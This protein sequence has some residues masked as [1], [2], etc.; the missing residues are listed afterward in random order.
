MAKQQLDINVGV[1]GAPQVNADLD[2]IGNRVQRVNELADIG[3]SR[4]AGRATKEIREVGTIGATL[5]G[6]QGSNKLTNQ[7]AAVGAGMYAFNV[8][9]TAALNVTKIL[10]RPENSRNRWSELLGSLPGGVG[11]AHQTLRGILNPREDQQQKEFETLQANIVSGALETKTRFTKLYASARSEEIAAR[12]RGYNLMGQTSARIA[13]ENHAEAEARDHHI[14]YLEL[15]KTVDVN[16][17]ASLRER[18]AVSEAADRRAI[19]VARHEERLAIDDLHRSTQKQSFGMLHGGAFVGAGERGGA[20]LFGIQKDKEAGLVAIDEKIKQLQNAHGIDTSKEDAAAKAEYS[21]AQL[22]RDKMAGEYKSQKASSLKLAGDENISPAAKERALKDINVHLK[23]KKAALDAMNAKLLQSDRDNFVV[24]AARAAANATDKSKREADISQLQK[25]RAELEKGYAKQEED[26]R[27]QN[28]LAGMD[29]SHGLGDMQRGAVGGAMGMLSGN[30]FVNPVLKLKFQTQM[31]EMAK[32]SKAEEMD[33]QIKE[34]EFSG[35]TAE[36]ERMKKGKGAV[37]GAFDIDIATAKMREE[38]GVA[39]P[40]QKVGANSFGYIQSVAGGG[41]NSRNPM[42]DKI[43]GMMGELT[44]AVL[45][46]AKG[47]IAL[48]KMSLP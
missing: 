36:A 37:M 42:I 43:A 38:Q 46:M 47:P 31:A 11:A 25:E 48:T 18:W 3:R 28:I 13:A 23:E 41:V 39:A 8:A 16:L 45:G 27:K 29:E 17:M 9:A 30:Q 7:I 5:F 15:R 4:K 33:R 21:E 26:Q 40:F 44:Q 22:A 19:D 6:I 32:A 35:K 12:S 1:T 24:S 20:A 2:K 10:T 34:L 14:Q